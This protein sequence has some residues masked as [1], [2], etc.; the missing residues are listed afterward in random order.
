M[1]SVIEHR[2]RI[3]IIGRRHD[4]VVLY[5]RCCCSDEVIETKAH[6]ML[7]KRDLTL[8]DATCSS[9]RMTSPFAIRSLARSLTRVSMLAGVVANYDSLCLFLCLFLCVCAYVRVRPS[10]WGEKQLDET[11]MHQPTASGDCSILAVSAA[12]LSDYAG[13]S[14]VRARRSIMRE[15]RASRASANVETRLSLDASCAIL[16]VRMPVDIF[17]VVGVR[18]SAVEGGHGPSSV[19]PCARSQGV[20][21]WHHSIT[22][23]NY[24]WQRPRVAH[25]VATDDGTRRGEPDSFGSGRAHR[26]SAGVLQDPR[27][28]QLHSTR[29]G[30]AAMVSA[31]TREWST[32]ASFL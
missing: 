2:V 23:A 16:P 26:R 10:V 3:R 29:C 13:C 18:E 31:R 24:R 21:V 14:L 9:V 32:R 22:L 5:A 11:Q 6:K 12:R 1:H 20:S 25:P 8:L 7:M 15:R 17:L 19:V 30:Q 28:G 27:D 4:C